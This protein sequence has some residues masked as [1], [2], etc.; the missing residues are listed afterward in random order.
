M[1]EE[2]Q[3]TPPPGIK[4][5]GIAHSLGNSLGTRTERTLCGSG[6]ADTPAVFSLPIS[7]LL[8]LRMK[9]FLETRGLRKCPLKV[10]FLLCSPY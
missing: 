8:G 3:G 6:I 5:E 10:L 7:S 1:S 9:L 2:I 4:D